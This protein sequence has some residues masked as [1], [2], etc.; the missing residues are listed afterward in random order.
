MTFP[1]QI[2]TVETRGRRDVSTAANT[3]TPITAVV[4]TNAQT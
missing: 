2:E 1:S 4:N 3:T